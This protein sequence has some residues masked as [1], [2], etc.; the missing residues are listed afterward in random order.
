MLSEINWVD[1]S[2]SGVPEIFFRVI[3]PFS[4][5]EWLERKKIALSFHEKLLWIV[6][7]LFFKFHFGAPACSLHKPAIQK[8]NKGMQCRSYQENITQLCEF[9]HSE[10]QINVLIFRC[11]RIHGRSVCSR[12]KGKKHPVINIDK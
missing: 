3:A 10:S 11:R 7:W 12:K 6:R 9:A 1:C 8:T 2:L 4:K 5:K